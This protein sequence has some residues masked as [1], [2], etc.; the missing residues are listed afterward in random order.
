[1]SAAGTRV[2]NAGPRE[3][4]GVTQESPPGRGIEFSF[5]REKMFG[6]PHELYT[7]RSRTLHYPTLQMGPMTAPVHSGMHPG[8]SPKSSLSEASTS[9]GDAVQ[10]GFL[11]LDEGG[12]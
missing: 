9:S 4:R 2:R 12:G 3:H 1:V 7:R 5:G 10:F 8:L 11:R 6:G